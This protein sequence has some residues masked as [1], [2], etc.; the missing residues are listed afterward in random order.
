MAACQE[1]LRQGLPSVVPREF[2]GEHR[3]IPL[4]V[5]INGD[6]AVTAFLCRSPRGPR[7]GQPGLETS[8]FQRRDGTWAYLGGGAGE[9]RDYP[10]AERP[11]AASQGGYLSALGYGQTCLTKPHRFPWNARHAAHAMLRPAQRFT[12][13][14]L[15]PG[16]LT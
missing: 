16:W 13:S 14:R 9:F 5:D 7:A 4:A 12:G 8:E 3:F 2:S 15:A 1:L 11:Q 6:L 10:L